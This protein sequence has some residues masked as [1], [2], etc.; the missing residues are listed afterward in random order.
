MLLAVASLITRLSQIFSHH[1]TNLK[2][3]FS[4]FILDFSPVSNH[5][6]SKQERSRGCVQGDMRGQTGAKGPANPTTR[7][8]KAL[9]RD[10]L[11]MTCFPSLNCL[12]PLFSAI[13]MPLAAH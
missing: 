7:D 3:F 2:L 13:L 10:T 1:R 11:G 4:Y 5:L 12:L 8:L 9:S 6:Y